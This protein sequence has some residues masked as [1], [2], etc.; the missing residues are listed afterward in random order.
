MSEAW[1]AGWEAGRLGGGPGLGAPSC[2]RS[3]GWD[4]AQ[5]LESKQRK[6][7]VARASGVLSVYCVLGEVNGLLSSR[8]LLSCEVV[9]FP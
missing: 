4:V 3:S 7:S 1:G 5:V 2:L 6:W 8:E 9:L